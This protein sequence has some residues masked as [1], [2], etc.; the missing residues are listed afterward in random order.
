MIEISPPPWKTEKPY[1]GEPVDWIEQ[2]RIIEV[3]GREH[4]QSRR[5]GVLLADI[6]RTVAHAHNPEVARFI[7]KACNAHDELVAALLVLLPG[8]ELDLR[9]ADPDDDL[10]AMRSRVKTVRDAL[11]KLN[12][13]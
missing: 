10:D 5:L 6:H 12:D 13:A 4:P 9:Y 2:C 3:T 8:L 7:V 11:A 1:S